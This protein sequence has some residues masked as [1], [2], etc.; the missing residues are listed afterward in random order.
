MNMA[1]YEKVMSYKVCVKK[2]YINNFSA[3]ERD[4]FPFKMVKLNLSF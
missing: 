3:L 1:L 4:I 2:Q